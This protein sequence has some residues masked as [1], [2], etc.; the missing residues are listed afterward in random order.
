[1]AFAKQKQL[2]WILLRRSN[3][4]LSNNEFLLV[5]NQKE[6]EFIKDCNELAIIRY[7][8]KLKFKK[9]RRPKEKDEFAKFGGIKKEK[10]GKKQ[11]EFWEKKDPNLHESLFN[12]SN[13]E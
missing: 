11:K 7:K 13:S 9:N 6:S 5:K 2:D 8:N 12:S 10:I 1:M 4:K 3:F